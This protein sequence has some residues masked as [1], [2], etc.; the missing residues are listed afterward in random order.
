MTNLFL[1]PTVNRRA[2]ENFERTVRRQVPLSALGG[3]SPAAR[4]LARA[5][6]G[7]L[8]AWGSMAGKGDTNV[9]TWAAM[10]P[11]DRVLFYFDGLFPVCARVV[12]SDHSP[13]VAKRLWGEEGGQTW[14]YMY[15]L[16]DVRQVDIPRLP[17]V[18]K[19]GYSPDY[20]PRRFSR[21][22]SKLEAKYGSV[23]NVLSELA[24]LGQEFHSMVGAAKAGDEA[25]A[26]LAVDQL[27][28]LSEKALL[29]SL[30]HFLA[31]EPP[32]VRREVVKRIK[33]NRRLVR[34]LKRLY[35]GCCQVCGTTI[36]KAGG[37]RY[38]EAAHLRPIS[39]LEANLDIRDNL[40]ILCPNHH[41][42]L[43]YGALRI[44]W[45]P[46]GVLVAVVA[47]K[48]TPMTNK[49]VAAPGGKS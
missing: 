39:L 3:L 10:R 6:R 46:S 31:S 12:V 28:Q 34:D 35:K 14:E 30:A 27:D 8:A 44:E 41:K 17:A 4:R 18:R 24:G 16:D 5:T 11:G 25:A 47:G 45:D 9:S 13:A 38:C 32:A 22:A 2:R 26:V 40:V 23:E 21:V 49:H 20:F 19:L 33:R 48:A 42:M 15:L 7:D 29:A 36:E 37:G 43:D 1:V